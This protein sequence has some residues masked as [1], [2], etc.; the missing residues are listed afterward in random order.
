[1]GP[2]FIRRIRSS[3][4]RNGRRSRSFVRSFVR[5]VASMTRLFCGFW[6]SLFVLSQ[7][8]NW[9]VLL[10]LLLFRCG[11][12]SRR[13]CYS[14]MAIGLVVVGT[15]LCLSA[16]GRDKITSLC[17]AATNLPLWS[18]LNL[19]QTSN[20][21]STT[22]IS[23]FLS[24]HNLR[25]FLSHCQISNTL[26][27]TGIHSLDPGRIIPSRMGHPH[28][29]GPGQLQCHWPAYQLLS[30]RLSACTGMLCG[31]VCCT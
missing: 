6:P 16:F 24:G 15:L 14:D 31:L 1:M 29:L 28:P 25:A 11:N 30:V 21:M 8:G 20:F 17:W 3:A 26:L 4:R 9:F 22:V 12:R 13:C 7:Y 10:L 23:F 27:R 19:G 18:S 5:S 2:S